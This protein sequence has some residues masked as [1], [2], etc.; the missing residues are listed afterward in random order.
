M[1]DYKKYYN[2]LTEEEKDE[3]DLKFDDKEDDGFFGFIFICYFGFVLLVLGLSTF[4][5]LYLPYQINPFKTAEQINL[6]KNIMIGL[7]T[8]GLGIIFGIWII[9]SS[10]NIKER[11][12]YLNEKFDIVRKKKK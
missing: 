6:A 7:L 1:R 9:C 11:D 3:F 10:K 4:D 8:G 2:K 12:K 5:L